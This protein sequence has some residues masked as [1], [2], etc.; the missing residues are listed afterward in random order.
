MIIS[1]SAASKKTKKKQ[2]RD[3]T[4]DYDELDFFEVSV[5]KGTVSVGNDSGAAGEA[6]DAKQIRLLAKLT[7][8]ISVESMNN[9]ATA[10]HEAMNSIKENLSK[11]QRG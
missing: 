7:S 4:E 6:G 9:R 5:H 2:R 3:S 10:S 11:S 1:Q 8:K